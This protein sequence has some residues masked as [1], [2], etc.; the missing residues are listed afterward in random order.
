MKLS[1]LCSIAILLT[2]FQIKGQVFE[3]SRE[4]TEEE[5]KMNTE[6]LAVMMGGTAAQVEDEY[7]FQNQFVILTETINKKGK[8]ESSYEMTFLTSEEKSLMGVKINQEGVQSEMVYDLDNHEMVTLMRT[9]GQKM[10]TTMKIDKS[11]VDAAKEEAP[12][13]KNGMPKFEKTGNTKEISG[14]NCDEYVVKNMEGMENGKVVY[15]MTDETEADWIRSMSRMSG[16]N[17]N[18]PDFYADSGY[19]EN[20][21]VIQT[22]MTDTKGETVRMTVKEAQTGGEF[23]ISTDGYTFMNLGG[24]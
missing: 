12:T 22:I 23:V 19:P 1:Y 4:E 16:M 8:V 11:L 7:T 17:K 24:R 14:Y 15:W 3:M 9:G 21:A 13:E 20:G 2:S 6:E 18:M 5:A 10:G